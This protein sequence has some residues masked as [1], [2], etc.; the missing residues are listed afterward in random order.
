MST[1]RDTA[2]VLDAIDGAL[3][4]WETSPDAM[5][6]TPPEDSPP[7]TLRSVMDLI[8]SSRTSTTFPRQSPIDSIT[9]ALIERARARMREQF[10]T[11]QVAMQRAADAADAASRRIAEI[12]ATFDNVT[13]PQFAGLRGFTPEITWLDEAASPAVE[14]PE[15]TPRERALRLRRERNTGPDPLRFHRRRS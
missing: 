14:E 13:P 2:G 10:A 12:A 7:V 3:G 1:G 6:W 9:P 11:T 5:R 8:V 4:D 15:E